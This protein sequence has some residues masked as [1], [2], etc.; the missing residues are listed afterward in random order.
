MSKPVKERRGGERERGSPERGFHVP[1]EKKMKIGSL[2]VYMIQLMI[3]MCVLAQCVPIYE[4]I[5]VCQI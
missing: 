5:F 3:R 2:G 4:C 1:G